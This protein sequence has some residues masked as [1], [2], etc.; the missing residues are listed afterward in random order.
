MVCVCVCVC[1]F[2]SLPAGC[3]SNGTCVH[4]VFGVCMECV[5][6]GYYVVCLCSVFVSICDVVCV[7][8]VNLLYVYVDIC[9]VCVLCGCMI[10]VCIFTHRY[11]LTHYLQ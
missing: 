11:L 2:G 4:V 9:C 8:Y 3:R 5:V 6:C 1:V 7:E 10:C